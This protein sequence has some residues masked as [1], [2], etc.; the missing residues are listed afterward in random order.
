[1][2]LWGCGDVVNT[3]ADEI[4]GYKS[5]KIFNKTLQKIEHKRIILSGSQ[6]SAYMLT[7]LLF[8]IVNIAIMV[9]YFELLPKYEEIDGE[10]VVI[11]ES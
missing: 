5:I 1:M 4:D 3:S 10:M 6:K 7:F 11:P 8:N 9:G 2:N